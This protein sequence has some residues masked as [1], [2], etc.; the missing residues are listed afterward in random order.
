MKKLLLLGLLVFTTASLCKA[1]DTIVKKEGEILRVKIT[2][3]GIEEIK[4]KMTGVADS[5]IMALKKSEVKR[6][7]VGGQVIINEKDAPVVKPKTEDILVKQDGSTLK[8]NVLEIGTDEIKFR[9]AG[10]PDG[11]IIS[12]DKKDIRT[13]KVG[14]QMVVDN[15]K[16]SDDIITKKDGSSLKVKVIDLGTDMVSFKLAGNPDG[17]TMTLKKKDIKT[18]KIDGQI[19]YEYKEDPY[20]ISNN[21][22]LNKTND[23]KMEFFAPLFNHL[24]FSY[25]WMERPGFNWEAGLGFIGLG[26]G[27]NSQYSIYNL[28]GKPTGFYLRGGPKF[29]L[30]SSSDV[31][32]E[33]ARIAHPLK[34]RYFK[35]EAILQSMTAHFSADTGSAPPYGNGVNK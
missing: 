32:V 21:S 11:P 16:E 15:K 34:G 28:T 35:I 8:V 31:E 14:D 23:I 3:I 29:L 1:Q 13:L 33:G 2:E 4:F 22:I 24:A 18:V 19:V 7:V 17:P 10:D 9:L 20:A 30:G 27:D 25:E 5:P 26:V 6:V 12:L